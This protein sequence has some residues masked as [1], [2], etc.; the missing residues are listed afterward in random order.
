MEAENIDQLILEPATKAG[1]NKAREHVEETFLEG[2]K[3]RSYSLAKFPMLLLT[4]VVNETLGTCRL[5]R[6]S[7][8]SHY[9]LFFVKWSQ[10]MGGAIPPADLFITDSLHISARARLLQRRQYLA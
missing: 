3:S 8:S 1:T 2:L 7:C 6:F 10:F 4:V 9:C 5:V